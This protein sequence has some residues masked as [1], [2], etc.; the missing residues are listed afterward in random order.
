MTRGIQN[1]AGD[2]SGVKGPFGFIFDP[3]TLSRPGGRLQGIQFLRAIAAAS[4]AYN[5]ILSETLRNA[6]TALQIGKLPMTAGVDIFFVISGFIM[7]YTTHETEAGV[8]TAY[9][10]GLRRL[11]RIVPI[12]WIFTSIL[13]IVAVFMP[14]I[15]NT[16]EADG[17]HILASYLFWPSPEATGDIRPLLN[18]G[19]TLNYEMYFYAWFAIGL[20]APRA[21][22]FPVVFGGVLG[23]VLL[24]RLMPDA[25]VALT[26]WGNLVV[27]EFLAGM[28]LAA[29]FFRHPVPNSLLPFL[30]ITAISLVWIAVFA[31]TDLS[32]GQRVVNKGVGAV[33]IVYAFTCL[34][35]QE[36]ALKLFRWSSVF[37]DASYALYL[38]HLFVLRALAIVWAL[39]VGPD[40]ALE[41]FVLITFVS[42][43]FASVYVWAWAERPLQ[44]LTRKI[45]P[46]WRTVD[47]ARH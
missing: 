47:A 26:Y 13:V 3:W 14:Q 12:Y 8:H 10:F 11:F 41:V 29:V 7:V 42:S 27:L 15:L 28:L 2:R 46:S 32:L 37:G 25:S 23:V 21:F 30:L 39:L 36:V 35:P 31:L 16:V 38:C 20:F 40:V 9:T 19:W 34:L 45:T 1:S 43:V 24:A 4:V 18:V 22:L 17:G 44:S 6:N 33:L 5:H